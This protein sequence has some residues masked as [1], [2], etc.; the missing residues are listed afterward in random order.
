MMNYYT[1]LQWQYVDNNGVT[2]ICRQ[3]L[4]FARNLYSS[5]LLNSWDGKLTID[6]NENAILAQMISAGVKN[7]NNTF[8][9]VVMGNWAER[10]DTSL[11]IPGLYGIKDGAQVFGFKTDGT[12]FIGA[13]GRG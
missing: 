10:A 7:S 13:S 6:E 9:G 3:A 8:T 2:T 12:G 5:S 4:P 11:D 1:V